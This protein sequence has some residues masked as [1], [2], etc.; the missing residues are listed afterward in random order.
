MEMSQGKDGKTPGKV[1]GCFLKF[2]LKQHIFFQ[3][4]M[5]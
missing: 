2:R 5:E 3:F 1:G 4:F